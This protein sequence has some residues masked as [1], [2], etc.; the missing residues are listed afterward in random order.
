M[1]AYVNDWKPCKWYCRKCGGHNIEYRQVTS[2]DEAHE[3]YN[4]RCLDCKYNWWVDGID[5]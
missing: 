2:F 3:D 4:Y 5:Y 1:T